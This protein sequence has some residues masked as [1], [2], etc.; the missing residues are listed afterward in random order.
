[1]FIYLVFFTFQNV[2]SMK[3]I[4]YLFWSCLSI[5][6]AK[7]CLGQIPNKQ[8]KPVTTNAQ[9]VLTPYDYTFRKLQYSG[10]ILGSQTPEIQALV[11]N[12]FYFSAT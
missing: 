1:M 3:N 6:L 12:S 4:A 11:I 5:F 10:N 8:L 7:C 2:F 9:A